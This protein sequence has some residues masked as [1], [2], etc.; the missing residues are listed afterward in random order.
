M[1]PILIRFFFFFACSMLVHGFAHAQSNQKY[2]ALAPNLKKQ[3]LDSQAIYLPSIAFY[4][5]ARFQERI[6]IAPEKYYLETKNNLFSW[7]I[8]PLDTI[9]ICFQVF[10][11][12]LAQTWQPY[13]VQI[14][15][16]DFAAAERAKF[17]INTTSSQDFFGGNSIQKNGSLSRGVGFG[18]NQ[19]LGL[20]SAL[21]L[22][23]SGQLTPNLTFWLPFQM[24]IYPYNLMEIQINCRNLTKFS[25]RYTMTD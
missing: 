25:F 6:Q 15:P 24:L 8:A 11:F 13:P 22:Q 19:S 2:V 21:N 7:L 23:L 20:Q 5:D 3:F 14:N 16:I 12:Q 1:K 18:N 17:Q 4:A 9:Y 10:P